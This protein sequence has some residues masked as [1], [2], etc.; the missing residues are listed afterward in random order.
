MKISKLIYS[1]LLFLG[2]FISCKSNVSPELQSL[3]DE[4]MEI[5]DEVMPKM[6][7]TH[8]L[9]KGLKK[10]LKKEIEEVSEV[11]GQILDNIKALEVA[12]DGMMDWMKNYKKLRKLEEGVNPM[13][14]YKQEKI[15]IQ[16]VSDDMYSAINNAEKFLQ[17][18]SSN[19]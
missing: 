5:H 3:M 16:K 15:N 9:R 4:V 19:N 12:D 10:E 13:D 17:A 14:Y 11:R 7:D 2:L 6:S 1:R 8:R 18:R